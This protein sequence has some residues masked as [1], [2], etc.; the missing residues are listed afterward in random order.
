MD[1]FAV[2]ASFA[3]GLVIGILIDKAL[4]MSGKNSVIDKEKLLEECFGEHMYVSRFSL[5]QARDWI[6]MRQDKIK[7]GTK[8]IVMKITPE[9]LKSLG[10]NIEIAQNMDNY[11]AI[12]VINGN[13]KEMQDSIL[14][15]YDNLD[16]K[17]EELLDRGDGTLVV[18]V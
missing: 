18:G 2:S 17:L 6:K 4:S 3:A 14:V 7:D 9:T 12:A 8:A 16:E 10:K 1:F 11:L 15:K 13:T 5:V